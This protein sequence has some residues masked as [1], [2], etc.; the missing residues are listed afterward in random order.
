MPFDLILR[1]GRVI[2][3][4]TGLDDVR[5]IGISAGTIG[6]IAARLP[7]DG[8]PVIDVSGMVVAPGFIDL[9]S[10]A[11][12]IAGQRVQ[13]CDGVTTALD[14]EG[15][16]SPIAVAYARAADQGR[17]I[18]FG[19]SASW[20]LSRMA[21][22]GGIAV[23]G[24]PGVFRQHIGVPAWQ[25][26]ASPAE[27][28][29]VLDAISADLDAGGLGIGVLLGYAP[30][31]DPAEYLAVA[32]LGA[33]RAVPVFTHTRA[34][35]ELAP[36]IPIDGAEEIARAA[37]TTGARMHYCHINSTS[38]RH[39]ERVY[40]EVD[41]AN[42]AGASLTT[43]AYPYGAGATGIGATF[44]N[45]AN[46]GRLG[47]KT[48]DITYVPTGERV[49]DAARLDELRAA[50][51]GGLAIHDFL[52]EDDPADRALMLRPLR[53]PGTI[54]ASDAMPLEWLGPEPD[55]LTWPL[56]PSGITHPRTAGTFARA[57]KIM[58]RELGRPVSEA[59]SRCS[60]LPARVLESA[61]PAMRA[62]GRLQPGCDADLVVFDPQTIS[63]TSTYQ[64]ST[65]PSA[66]I[67]YVFVHG[68]AVVRAGQL[69]P[70]AFPGRP[71]YA[72]PR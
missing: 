57:I 30:R 3:P 55:P 41:R 33:V 19:F 9:H 35:A 34:L 18:N 14:L 72:S 29:C 45:P 25:R 46:L 39:L 65:R 16:E 40:G 36:D 54:I 50:D 8:S 20:A 48:T 4:E 10:H 37:E 12:S 49:R 44:L 28:A 22:V 60:L 51:P 62:K 31:I 53:T 26:S 43:E 2:D 7:D 17:P 67:D 66:G 59:V 71:V 6:Q 63:D 56:P 58:T 32:G 27:V 15:G 23:T 68:V 47:I 64:A 52:D 38:R 42:A 69:E 11:N 24:I 70:D 1:A 61:V 5:D 13:A 21:Q